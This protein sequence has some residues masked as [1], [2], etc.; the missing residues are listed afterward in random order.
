[1][2]RSI[3]ITIRIRRFSI[4]IRR[5]SLM[6]L[7]FV[8]FPGTTMNGGSPTG[9]RIRPLRWGNWHDDDC[10]ARTF[11]RLLTTP[12]LP[13]KGLGPR[14]PERAHGG[15]KVTDA[16]RIDRILPNLH[17]IAAKGA[18]VII[19]SHLGRPKRTDEKYS[20]RP[21]VGRIVEARLGKPVAFAAD[22]IGEEARKAVAAMARWRLCCCS[23][24]PASTQGEEKNDPKPSSTELAELGDIYRQRRFFD[25]ASGACL[26][27][28]PGAEDAV[29]S[30]AARCR[31][32]WR[33]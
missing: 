7:S 18:K 1:M 15:R 27:R 9:W 22:C 33:S 6:A 21:V 29:L 20:L 12:S 14:R 23:K 5:G 13:E 10:A 19:L 24:I 4:S 26:D 28:R 8:S 17:E 3:S 31:S 2:S 30:P 32:S 25:R 16:T 11:S